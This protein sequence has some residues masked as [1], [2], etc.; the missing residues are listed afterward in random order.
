MRVAAA[1]GGAGQFLSGCAVGFS[2]ERRD[3][4]R[5]KLIA[6]AADEVFG[7]KLVGHAAVVAEEVADS[8]V[9]LGVGEAP[10]SRICS[11]T[12]M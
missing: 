4:L 9:V 1:E 2:K 6:I 5:L 11:S 10:E 3:G 7:R 12:L 8:V